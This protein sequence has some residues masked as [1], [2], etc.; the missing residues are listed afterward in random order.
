MLHEPPINEKFS[1]VDPNEMP[2]NE[3]SQQGL[4]HL[5]CYHKSQ[6][7]WKFILA[8]SQMEKKDYSKVMNTMTWVL[9]SINGFKKRKW[10]RTV[11]FTRE[12][13]NVLHSKWPKLYG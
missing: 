13:L 10:R 6:H 9:F 5:Q 4:H 7:N 12:A 3:A 1:C 8:T 2:Q 11:R